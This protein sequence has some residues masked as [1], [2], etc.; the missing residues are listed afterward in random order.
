MPRTLA[1]IFLAL[2]C[3]LP[4]GCRKKP[5][6]K[7]AI[8]GVALNAQNKPLDKLIIKFH[9]QDEDNKF[10]SLE[11]AVNNGKF[12]GKLQPGRYKV[13]LAIIPIE[14]GP[15]AGGPGTPPQV[16]AASG[17]HGAAVGGIPS[18]YLTEEKT[19]WD[20]TIPADGNQ[21]MKLTMK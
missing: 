7:V 1:L 12:E 13:T 21:D 4:I 8:A 18:Q 15:G 3:L 19:P 10:S 11:T 16:P 9:P 2:A 17:K 20:V 14:V 6:P 5:L